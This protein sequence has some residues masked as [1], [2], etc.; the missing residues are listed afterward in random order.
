MIT[1]NE[2]DN[3][4]ECSHCRSFLISVIV[5]LHSF[6]LLGKYTVISNSCYIRSQCSLRL[7]VGTKEIIM[8]PE[9]WEDGQK[10]W[11]DKRVLI[12]DSYGNPYCYLVKTILWG[13]SESPYLVEVDEKIY[14]AQKQDDKTYRVSL[15]EEDIF[16]GEISK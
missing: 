1:G 14:I 4:F 15:K 2:T 10:S 11:P 13:P 5:M 6:K 16:K 8:E 9:K 12:C 7:R 3:V